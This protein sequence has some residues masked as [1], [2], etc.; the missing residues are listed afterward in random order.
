MIVNFLGGFVSS[1]MLEKSNYF[2]LMELMGTETNP[3]AL[4]AFMQEN[5]LGLIVFMLYA[6]VLMAFVVAGIVLFFVNKR[7]FKLEAGEITIEKG[8]RF[9]TIILNVGMIL[10][11]VFWIGMIIW[12]LL[13]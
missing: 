9:K 2:E 6:M 7:K 3:E 11:C 4:M 10:Y 5:A 1:I 13:A 8:Q 12:Q